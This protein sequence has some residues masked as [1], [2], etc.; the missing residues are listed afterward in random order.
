MLERN[1]TVDLLDPR[2]GSVV[3]LTLEQ[4]GGPWQGAYSFYTAVIA[5]KAY[6]P[7]PGQR[8]LAG[9]FRIGTGDGFGQ[10]RDLP[11]FRRFFAGGINSTRGYDRDLVGP[12][13][14][15]DKPVGGRSL[16]ETSIEVRTPIYGPLGG[17]VF[18]DVGEV[19]RQPASYSLGDL[20]FGAGCG[21]RYHTLVGPLRVDV[22]FPFE[23]PPGQP[24]WRVH[25]SI[26]QAF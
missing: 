22:G 10:S 15:H 24:S 17:V 19:R 26:G 14:D 9:R 5:A 20:M 6:L 7:L 4:A 2:D 21:L 12:L 18:F 3:N 25:F 1:T 16:L 23:P 8:T 11:L 13:N